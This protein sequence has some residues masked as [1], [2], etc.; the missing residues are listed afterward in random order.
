MTQLRVLIAEDEYTAATLLEFLVQ[1]EGHEVCSIIS[2][3]A[4]VVEAV[5]R[6]KPD[7][8]LMDVH[9]ADDIS[10]ISATRS[11]L[12]L[13]SVPVII[14]SATDSPEDLREISESGALGFIK[15]P[16]STDAFK[17]ALR[18]ATRHHEAMR[19][20]KD[21]EVL[22]RGLFDYAAVGI[23]V[24]HKDGYFLT[25]NMAYARM[26]GYSGPGELLRLVRS[27]KEQVYGDDERWRN[28]VAELASGREIRDME[29]LVYGRDG[30]SIWVSEHL[31][32]SLD[33]DGNFE[34][35]EAVVIN[36]SD[37]KRAEAERSLAF[38]MLQNTVDAIADL[39]AVT[40]LRG[41][42]IMSNKA[43]QEQMTDFSK[44]GQMMHA[45]PCPDGDN[46]FASFLEQLESE[47]NSPHKIRGPM[48]FAGRD[49]HMDTSIS[50]YCSP[51]GE[52]VGAV[53]V[54]R[55]FAKNRA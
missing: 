30:D 45:W 26:L 15:K 4:E 43:F 33:E 18:I 12:R 35:Y 50:S 3:G 20:L 14:V 44:S 53:F 22:H 1:E 54:M 28:I 48:C 9:L 27:V 21:S 25:S 29:S 46:L 38:S 5:Q 11:L 34:H 24:C 49:E 13:V 47:P 32:P 37:K 31:T 52:V 19:K 42:V 10:G 39:V 16:V 55:P 8:V 23:Y 7:V 2:K 6:L 41:N 40:D 36:I 51:E 17:V